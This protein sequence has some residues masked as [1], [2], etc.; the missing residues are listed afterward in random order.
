MLCSEIQQN[1]LEIICNPDAN[2]LV[3][4]LHIVETDKESLPFKGFSEYCG[5]S[6]V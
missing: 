4:K 3:L 5:T 6:G 1:L 2:S